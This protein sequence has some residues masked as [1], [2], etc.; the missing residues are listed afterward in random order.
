MAKKETTPTNPEAMHEAK[1]VAVMNELV[2]NPD[3]H[4]PVAGAGVGGVA[5]GPTL[6]RAQGSKKRHVVKLRIAKISLAS[7]LL[8]S[9]LGVFGTESAGAVTK[10]VGVGSIGI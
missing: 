2:K 8:A 7:L 5:S 6:G 3:S 9:I 4:G 10:S 1:A